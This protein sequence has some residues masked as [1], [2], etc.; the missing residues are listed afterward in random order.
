MYHPKCLL[1]DRE[2]PVCN[3]DI[4]G[5]SRAPQ[6][7]PLPVHAPRPS[8]T[9]TGG[10][11]H[12]ANP[13][14]RVTGTTPAPPSLEAAPPFVSGFEWSS[15]GPSPCCSAMTSIRLCVHRKGKSF[16]T[17]RSRLYHKGRPAPLNLPGGPRAHVGVCA[18]TMKSKGR[19]CRAPGLTSLT[20]EP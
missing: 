17:F 3:T 9:C 6:P 13:G 14:G 2:P 11:R 8:D 18:D 12:P 7:P 4:P 16:L 10:K 15:S 1:Q 19:G 5:M 20:P